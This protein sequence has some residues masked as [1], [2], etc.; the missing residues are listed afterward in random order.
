MSK[1]LYRLSFL[2]KSNV[3]SPALTVPFQLSLYSSLVGFS[4]GCDPFLK[5]LTLLIQDVSAVATELNSASDAVI[6]VRE[7]SDVFF[8]N[9]R[10]MCDIMTL[11]W[12]LLF[13]L[14]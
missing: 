2:L 10:F 11:A 6:A 4:L 3:S 5:G 8:I 14:I 9:I 1:P 12:S 7:E 13:K